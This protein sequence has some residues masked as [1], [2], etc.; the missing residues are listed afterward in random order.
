M[1][2]VSLADFSVPSGLM[3][4]DRIRLYR[5]PVTLTLGAF[6]FPDNGTEIIRKSQGKAEAVIL[7]G[8]DSKGQEKQLAM[9]IYDGWDRLKIRKS[10]G[11]NP[12]SQN[13]LIVYGETRRNKQYGGADP[14]ILISQILTKESHLDFTDEELFPLEKVSYSDLLRAGGFGPVFLTFKNGRKVCV[15]FSRMEGSL[16]V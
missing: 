4:A 7:K 2:A 6:G 5:R 15:D 11:S 8:F 14:Y 9:T 1:Q 10:R 12:D 16:S 3:R 13:S